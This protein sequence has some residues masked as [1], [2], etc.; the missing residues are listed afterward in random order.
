MPLPITTTHAQDSWRDT[1]WHRWLKRPY[2]LAVPLD[3]GRGPTVVLLHGIASNHHNWT[4]VVPNIAHECRIIVPELLGFGDSP[5]PLWPQYRLQ[6][7]V[8]SVLY[9]LDRKRIRGPIVLVG[10][11]MGSLIAVEIARQ[12]PQLVRHLV[13]CGIPLY[14]N[15][16]EERRL[17]RS[18]DMYFSIYTRILQKPDF[19]IRGAALINK[20]LPKIVGFALNEK[21]WNAF[22]SSMRNTIMR[23]QTFKDIRTLRMPIDVISGR[24]DIFVLKRPQ[25][26]LAK[27]M[28][29]V[30]LHML[31]EKH[32]ISAGYGRYV[33]SVIDTALEK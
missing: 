19:T 14:I 6:D 18:S 1:V 4:H 7:H 9:T 5:K 2:K 27:L 17:K 32:E 23:Q 22:A 15:A 12:R 31:N 11:S 29:N 13:L 10:H 8:R 20:L 26:L 33:A 16:A 30:T 24:L 28:P 25:R 3:S 21:S